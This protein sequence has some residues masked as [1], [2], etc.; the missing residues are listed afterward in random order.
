MKVSLRTSWQNTRMLQVCKWIPTSCSIL[1]NT[2]MITLSLEPP[3]FHSLIVILTLPSLKLSEEKKKSVVDM[4][5]W[6]LSL[7]SLFKAMVIDLTPNSHPLRSDTQPI[8]VKRDM[9]N[10]KP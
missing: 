5:F 6:K 4:L 9:F 1:Q 3:V 10:L 2:A 7:N 8:E